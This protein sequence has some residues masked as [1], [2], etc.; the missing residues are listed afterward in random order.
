MSMMKWSDQEKIHLS[1]A[2]NSLE[3]ISYCQDCGSYSEL[4]LCHICSSPQRKSSQVICVV[5]QFSD[6]MAIEN[7]GKYQGLF[8]ILGG[9]LNPLAGIGPAQL[10]IDPLLK[11]LEGQE[12]TSLLLAINP[13]VEGDATCSYI[14]ELVGDNV[15]VER[16]GFGVPI[17]GSLEFLDPMTI[18]MALENKQVL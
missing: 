12:K 11:R 17:G 14:K 3:E 1:Q 5:E 6:F 8:H 13:S 7:S 10:R 2:I 16:I 9:V 4:D 18:T 15:V